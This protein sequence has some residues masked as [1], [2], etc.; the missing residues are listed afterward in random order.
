[1]S[2]PMPVALVTFVSLI[3]TLDEVVFVC[4]MSIP[5]APALLTIKPLS[6]TFAASSINTPAPVELAI[7]PPWPAVLLASPITT[8][9]PVTPFSTMPLVPPVTLT[10]S[11][12][13]PAPPT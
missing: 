10:D 13:T 1:M 8:A 2:T 12:A 9:P 11:N 5:L 3:V 6:V 4:E 7:V